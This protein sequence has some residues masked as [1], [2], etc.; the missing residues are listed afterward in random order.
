MG[1]GM[2]TGIR[3]W[4]AM[5]AVVVGASPAHAITAGMTDTFQA[6][7][8]GDW[9]AGAA[10]IE[11]PVV[12]ADGGPQGSGDG[13]LL[14]T[15]LG[16]VGAS[17]RL[18]A[19]AGPQWSGNFLAAGVDRITLDV[20][21]LG[22]TELDLRLWLAGA[23]GVTALSAVAVSVPAGGGWMPISFSLD[24][25]ALAGQPLSTL[26]G[27]LEMRLF[28]ASTPGFPGEAIVASLGIDNVTAVPEPAPAWLLLAGLAFIGA[29]RWPRRRG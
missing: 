29:R 11:S 1:N 24:A 4:L 3:Q 14:L 2:G 17:S 13:Y 7:A 23:A 28:H 9:G 16:G 21:N 15:S 26:A 5:A 25:G 20:S 10:S 19:I 18:T 6:G 27:V 8:D 22:A 12:V